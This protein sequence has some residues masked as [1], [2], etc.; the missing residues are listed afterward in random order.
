MLRPDEDRDDLAHSDKGKFEAVAIKV[1][2]S[3][4]VIT[5]KNNSA[6]DRDVQGG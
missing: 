4:S 5:W 1:C 6:A 3:R 2:T